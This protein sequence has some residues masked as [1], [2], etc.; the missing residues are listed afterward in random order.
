MITPKYVLILLALFGVILASSPSTFS[1]FANDHAFHSTSTSCTKCH[2]DIQLQLEDTG[3]VT[4]LHSTQDE[5]F[6][7]IYCH[8][9]VNNTLNRIQSKDYHSAY[10]PYCI[11]CHNSSLSFYEPKEAHASIITG[12][13]PYESGSESCIMCHTTLYDSIT[14]RNRVVF[15]FEHDSV[16]ANGTP[17]YN[18]SYTTTFEKTNTSGSHNFVDSVECFM[19]HFPIYEILDQKGK[20]YG[21]HRHFGCEGCHRGSGRTS[22]TDEE[23]ITYHAAKT[24]YCSDCH[25][26]QHIGNPRDC[27][28]CHTSHGGFKTSHGG[29]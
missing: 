8:S 2:K 17:E 27:N 1:L 3:N 5:D 6:G 19:C 28:Q 15:E 20:P 9:N 23:Q 10:T 25:T 24:K 11:E 14:I 4:I 13:T 7:C 12:S 18:G 16:T 21:M 29:Q 26:E 22:Q